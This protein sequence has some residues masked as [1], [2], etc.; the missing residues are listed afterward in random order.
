MCAPAVGVSAGAVDVPVT[1]NLENAS[2]TVRD[3]DRDTLEM[4]QVAA[5]GI[6][7]TAKVIFSGLAVVYLV[8]LGIMMM[9]ALGDDGEIA[10]AKRQAMYTVIAFLFVNIPGQIYAAFGD[11]QSTQIGSTSKTGF[12]IDPS[13]V[14]PSLLVNYRN[15]EATVTN[16]IVPFFEIVLV[17]IAIFLF[18]L[19]GIKMITSRGDEEFKKK[20]KGN[21]F[22]GVL[23]LIFVGIIEV[24]THIVYRGDLDEAQDLFAQLMN[25][26]IFFAGPAV[27]FFLIRG[28]YYFIISA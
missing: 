10:K 1:R 23:A 9:V 27:V 18:T 4:T 8:Y 6:L 28:A 2:V 17:G 26:A 19:S 21:I 16:G 5:L 12:Q 13:P 3:T 20:A 7:Q 11:K 15:W 25:L 24:W 22:Y 14:S